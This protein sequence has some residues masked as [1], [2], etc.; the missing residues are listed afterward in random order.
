MKKIETLNDALVIK[1]KALYDIE[2]QLLKALPKMAK[3]STDPDL[4]QGFLDHLKET[5]GQVK[6]LEKV[7]KLLDLKPTKTKAEGIRGIIA[8]A[9]WIIDE[10]PEKAVLDSMLIANASYVEHYEM[11][12]YIAAASWA[13][14]LGY[15][16]IAD[17]LDETLEEEQA[18]AEKL[19]ALADDKIDAEAI[20][21][22]EEESE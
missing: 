16:E 8:D 19:G 18:A 12:G 5:E 14:A 6:R 21:E 7:F 13:T 15:T 17:L 11:A 4:K 2:N 10:K 20:G 22:D 1:I 3:N 9:Q